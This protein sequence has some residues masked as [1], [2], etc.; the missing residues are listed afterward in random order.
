MVLVSHDL[1]EPVDFADQV[2]LLTKRP[3]RLAGILRREV[4]R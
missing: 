3:I 1:E 4:R 2:L